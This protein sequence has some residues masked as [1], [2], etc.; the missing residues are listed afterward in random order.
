[1][2]AAL[3]QVEHWMLDSDPTIERA[4][5]QLGEALDQAQEI[6]I[7]K[8]EAP[9]YPCVGHAANAGRALRI[10]QSLDQAKPG[11]ASTVLLMYAEEASQDTDDKK[12]RS[13]CQIVSSRETWYL[14]ACSS[15]LSGFFTP[16]MC[17]CVKSFR[18]AS[19]T[20]VDHAI[21]PL[22]KGF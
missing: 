4:I 9:D 15:C 11:T 22:S 3:E 7:N 18:T 6:T 16:T 20:A 8:N 17:H 13:L 1:M 10:L 2:I 5:I 14:N 19:H 12:R 21:V